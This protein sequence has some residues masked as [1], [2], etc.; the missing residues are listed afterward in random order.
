M[1]VCSETSDSKDS[2]A[3]VVSERQEEEFFNNAR[4][5]VCSYSNLRKKGPKTRPREA[6]ED[7]DQEQFES[8]EIGSRKGSR[9]QSLDVC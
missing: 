1:L 9:E 4:I 6:K 3:S 8:E 2:W 7:G 5:K